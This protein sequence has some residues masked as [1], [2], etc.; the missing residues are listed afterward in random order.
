MLWNLVTA[1]ILKVFICTI[2]LW[3]GNMCKHKI[4]LYY[5]YYSY[6]PKI[7]L[8]VLKSCIWKTVGVNWGFRKMCHHFSHHHFS[9]LP[10]SN[11]SLTI[12]TGKYL[13]VQNRAHH[14]SPPGKVLFCFV[15]KQKSGHIFCLVRSIRKSARIFSMVK[16]AA[17]NVCWQCFLQ[18]H[19]SH[20]QESDRCVIYSQMITVPGL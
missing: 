11:N 13:A 2:I 3:M 6:I 12:T 18:R 17:W 9:L 5:I 16:K 7:I 1:L 8:H 20:E 19:C 15:F 4:C 14:Q 10:T